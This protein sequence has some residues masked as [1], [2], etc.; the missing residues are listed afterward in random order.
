MQSKKCSTGLTAALTVLT[1]TLLMLAPRA[2]AQEKVLY[3]FNLN[4]YGATPQGGLTLRWPNL[5]CDSQSVRKNAHW[6]QI[7][8]WHV[9][10]AC[11]APHRD[12]MEVR[13]AA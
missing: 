3:D 6:R 13:V 8:L 12:D 1:V 11:E 4:K 2:V 9:V 10:R 5:R 7:C